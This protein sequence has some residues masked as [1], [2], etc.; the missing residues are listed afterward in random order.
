MIIAQKEVG[1]ITKWIPEVDFPCE[2]IDL[3]QQLTI[4]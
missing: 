4:K 3:T 1:E 2:C